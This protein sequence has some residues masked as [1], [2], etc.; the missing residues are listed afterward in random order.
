MVAGRQVLLDLG[1]GCA[2]VIVEHQGGF[3]QFALLP[4]CREL[5]FG[6]E[7]IVAAVDLGGAPRP[8]RIGDREAQGRITLDQLLDQRGLASTGGRRDDEKA[9]GRGHY[10][11][12]WICSRICSINTLRST[13]AR[14]VSASADL[15]PRVLASRFSSC[16]MKSRR[17]PT[18]SSLAR[19]LRTSLT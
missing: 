15:D 16:I 18:G 7:K 9:G 13:A 1:P 10:S 5:G 6:H 11:T 17:R 3:E 14:V 8:R 19:A 4:E 12:F 2:V